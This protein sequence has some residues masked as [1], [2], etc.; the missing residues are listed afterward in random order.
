[1]GNDVFSTLQRKFMR[2]APVSRKSCCIQ[3]VV[4]NFFILPT[5]LMLEL[6]ESVLQLK[7]EFLIAKWKRKRIKTKTQGKKNNENENMK[8]LKIQRNYIWQKHC[9]PTKNNANRSEINEH[10]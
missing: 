2:L 10:Q 4:L 6:S 1:M 3:A 8:S 9:K 5:R 7:F